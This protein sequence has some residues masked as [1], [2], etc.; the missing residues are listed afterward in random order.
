MPRKTQAPPPKKAPVKAPAK[1]APVVAAAEPAKPRS[2]PTHTIELRDAS[3][4]SVIHTLTVNPE[5]RARVYH[6]EGQTYMAARQN[7]D[8]VWVYRET[9]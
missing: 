6:Y 3:E 9:R 2:A 5:E 8:G 1:A 7:D 4:L